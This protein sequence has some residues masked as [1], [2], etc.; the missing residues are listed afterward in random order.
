MGGRLRKLDQTHSECKQNLVKIMLQF[1]IPSSNL[2][3]DKK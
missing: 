2:I 3:D 1:Q